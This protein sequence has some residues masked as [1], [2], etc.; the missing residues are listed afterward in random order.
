MRLIPLVIA[1]LL[2]ACS[3]AQIGER[4]D[5]NKNYRMDMGLEVNGNVGQGMIVVPLAQSYYIKAK[6]KEDPELVTIVTC[7]REI[8]LERQND[9]FVFTFTPTRVESEGYCPMFISAYSS[10]VWYTGGFID[11]RL[12]KEVAAPATVLCNGI[13]GP[14]SN[15]LGSSV[16]QSRSG[17]IQQISFDQEMSVGHSVKCEDPK[18]SDG[19]IWTFKT[20][21]GDCVHRFFSKSNPKIQHR[22]STHGYDEFIYQ[23]R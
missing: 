3:T 8:T 6:V 1:C 12:P 10:K 22:L 11:V 18:S 9:S 23:K 21:S 7:H 13:T 20:E 19:K 4:L 15:T 14:A 16:C 17:L 5:V 2:T